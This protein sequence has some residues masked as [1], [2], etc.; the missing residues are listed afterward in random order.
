M[1]NFADRL[2]TRTR[3]L[4]HPLCIGL[5]P[6]LDRIPPEFHGK[7]EPETVRNFF[8]AFLDLAIDKIAIVKPRI[9]LFERIGIPGLKVL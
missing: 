4:G 6:Y 7:S 8:S 3:E 2:T 5:D 9:A 1:E